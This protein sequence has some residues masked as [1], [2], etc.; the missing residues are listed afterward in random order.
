[1]AQ[2]ALLNKVCSY[3]TCHQTLQEAAFMDDFTRA[4]YDRINTSLNSAECRRRGH[5]L[6]LHHS[7]INSSS[8]KTFTYAQLMASLITI[9]D[10]TQINRYKV[11]HVI[12]LSNP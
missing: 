11:A 4:C 9:M 8:I 5:H 3:N 2:S 1:M 7:L 12:L 10:L 6:M